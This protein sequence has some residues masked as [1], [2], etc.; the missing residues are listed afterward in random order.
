MALVGR[1]RLTPVSRTEGR[2]LSMT[3]TDQEGTIIDFIS[4]IAVK[5]TP[6]EVHA[7]QVFGKR[8]S[9]PTFPLNP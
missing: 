7:V 9:A 2:D 6:E 1:L 5:A 8:C 3:A 4:G